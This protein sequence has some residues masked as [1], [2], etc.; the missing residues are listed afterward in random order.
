MVHRGGGRCDLEVARAGGT[1]GEGLTVL[2]G[3]RS[4]WGRAEGDPGGVMRAG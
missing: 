1:G 2:T 3:L 4:R